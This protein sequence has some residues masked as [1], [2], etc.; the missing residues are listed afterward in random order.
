M[1]SV[2]HVRELVKYPYMC[3]AVLLRAVQTD[4][5]KAV[6]IL[7][8]NER[9]LLDDNLF[10]YA[11]WSCCTENN[12]ISR[13]CCRAHQLKKLFTRTATMERLSNHLLHTFKQY[14][15]RR[16]ILHAIVVRK[17]CSCEQPHVSFIFG[18]VRVTPSFQASLSHSLSR[19]WAKERTG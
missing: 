10:N 15:H 2:N 5:L 6:R 18:K 16:E 19:R 14:I 17:S 11:V 8:E 9:G 12:C 4:L 13:K 7:W 1:V 3:G